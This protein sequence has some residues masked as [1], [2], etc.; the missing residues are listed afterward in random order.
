MRDD[1]LLRFTAHELTRSDLQGL[2]IRSNGPALLRAVWHFGMLA[3]TGTLI[4]TLRTTL[5]PARLLLA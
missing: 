1:A 2:M 5:Q 4:W 3:L